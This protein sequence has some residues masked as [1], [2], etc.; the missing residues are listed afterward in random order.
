VL[1]PADPVV[2]F[3]GAAVVFELVLLDLELLHAAS[4][5]AAI[6]HTPIPA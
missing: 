1:D 4:A 2:P 5:R 6:M 3:E